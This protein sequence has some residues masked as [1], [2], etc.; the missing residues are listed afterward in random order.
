MSYFNILLINLAKEWDGFVKRK[1]QGGVSTLK[2]IPHGLNECYGG[3][4]V[5]GVGVM[6][7]KPKWE[8]Q[9]AKPALAIACMR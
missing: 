4:K 3:R 7:D 9:Q 6:K 1:Y 8:T 2:Q 5:E